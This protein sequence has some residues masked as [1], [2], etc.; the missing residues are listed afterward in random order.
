MTIQDYLTF[1]TAV[2]K[3]TKKAETITYYI[4]VRGYGDIN[5]AYSRPST[6]KVRTYNAIKE[7]AQDTEGYNND[8]RVIGRNSNQYSTLYTFTEEGETYV[9]KD[10]K[11]NT[12]ITVL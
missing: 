5:N 10:T 11:D 8:L 6:T 2:K 4:N 1:A 12:Y 7:R 3:D 9:V